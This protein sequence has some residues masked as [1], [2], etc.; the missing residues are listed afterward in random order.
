MPT[1]ALPVFPKAFFPKGSFCGTVCATFA[2]RSGSVLRGTAAAMFLVSLQSEVN[3]FLAAS[4]GRLTTA[5]Y[6][7][8][9]GVHLRFFCGLQAP[10]T[11][12]DF[13]STVQFQTGLHL[14]EHRAL[15]VAERSK[16]APMQCLSRASPS[17]R[18]RCIPCCARFLAQPGNGKLSRRQPDSPGRPT[19]L[20]PFPAPRPGSHTPAPAPDEFA[21]HACKAG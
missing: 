8:S 20:Q 11:F 17:R 15:K 9:T 16:P 2:R 14:L 21:R 1:R 5:A 18:V 13:F 12:R 10:L 3:Y 19:A 4:S 7:K 6:T